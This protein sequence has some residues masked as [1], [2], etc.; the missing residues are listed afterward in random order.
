MD[1][2]RLKITRAATAACLCLIAATARGDGVAN[3]MTSKSLPPATLAVIDPESGTSSGGGSTDVN[4]GPGDVIFF[5][6]N[7]YPVP[8]KIIRGLNTYLTEYIPSN[9]QVVGVRILDENGLA[10]TPF[11][12]GIAMDDCG[13]SCNNFNSVPSSAG[14]R[15]LD[16]GTIAQLYADTGV[17]YA[18]RAGYTAAITT[19]T[20]NPST[21]FLALTNGILMDPEPVRVG[22][23]STLLGLVGDPFVHNRWDWAQVRAFGIS[24]PSGNASGNNGTGNTPFRYGSP[25]AGP[26]TFYGFETTE[27]S[28]G[29]LRFDD[30]VGPWGRVQ[31]PGATIGRGCSYDNRASCVEP[32]TN[33]LG[34]MLADASTRGL[35]ITPASP[36]PASARALRFAL[37]EARVGEPQVVEVALRVLSTPLDGVQME[38]VD[39][40]EIFGGDT[41]AASATVRAKDNAWNTHL[42][43]PACVYLKLKFDLNVDRAL[44]LTGDLLTYTLDGSNL[45]RFDQSSVVVRQ[46]YDSS[47]QA[48]VSAIPAPTRQTTCGGLACLEWDLATLTPGE[49]FVIQSQF[50]VGGGGQTTN[51]MFAE[52]TSTDIPRFETQALTIVRPVGVVDVS[53]RPTFDPTASF[54]SAGANA[55]LSGTLGNT[56]TGD[57]TVDTLTFDLPVSTWRPGGSLALSCPGGT[58]ASLA[59]NSGCATNRPTYRLNESI[60]GGR[61]CTFTVP[62]AVPAGTAAGLYPIAV[63]TWSSQTAFGG[64]SETWFRDAAILNVGQRRSQRPTLTCPIFSPQTTIAGTTTEAIGTTAR[65]YLGGYRRGS[66]GASVAGGAWTV[67]TF[68]DAT[69]FGALYGGLEVRATAQ[70]TGELESEKSDACFVTQLPVCGD[71]LDNDGD[72]LVD[73]PADPGCSATNDRDETDVQCSDGIDNDGDGRIDFPDDPECSSPNDTTEG[74]T[75]QCSDGID[76]DGDGV[77]DFPADSDCT[78]ATDRIERAQPA[79]NDGVDND[80]DGDVDFPDDVGCHSAQDTNEV[81]PSP[82]EGETRARLL[83]VLDSSGSM[84]WN[85]CSDTFTGGDGS[86][87]CAGGDVSC[88]TCG[89]IGCGDGVA[90][91]SRLD[92]AKR[93]LSQVVQGFG[94]VEYGLMRFHQRAMDFACPTQNASNQSG[95]WQGA[96]APVCG[97]GFNAADLLVGFSQEN[98]RDLLAWMDG[99]SGTAAV[100]PAGGDVEIRGSGTTPLAGSLTSAR[101]YLED[102]E[103][104]D[105]RASCRPYVVILVTD[106]VETCGGNPVAAANALRLAGYVTYVVGFAV[107][108]PAA[109]DSL[110]DIAAAGGGSPTAIFVSDEAE[111]ATRISDIIDDTVLVE[112]CNGADDDCDTLIDE[113]VQNACGACGAVP[114]ETCNGVDDDCDG[115]VDDGVR[116]ACGGCGPLP[117]EACNGLD[118]DCDG[119]TDEGGVCPCPAPSPELCDDSDNDCDGIVDEGLVRGCGTEVGACSAGTETCAAGVWGLCTGTGPTTETCNGLD[120][121]CDGIVDGVTRPCGTDVGVCQTGVEICV[122]GAFDTSTCVGAVTG[123]AELCNTLDDDCDGRTDEGT[124]PATSCGSSLGLCRP[125]TLRCVAGTLQCQGGTAPVAETCD[126]ADQDCDG[127]VDEGA[128]TDGPCG[129]STG[130][131]EPGVRTCVMGSYQCVGAVGPR[132]EMCNAVDDDCDG[133]LD[134]GNPGGGAVCGVTEGACEPG[135]TTCVGGTLTCVGGVEPV[136]ELCNVVDDDCDG[137]VDEGNPGGGAPCGGTDVGECELG[138]EACRAGA[139]VCVGERRPTTELCNGLDDDCDGNVDEGNPEAGDACG[140]DTGECMPGITACAGGELVCEGAIGPMDEVCNGLDDDCDGVADDGLD[141]GAPCGSDEGECIPGF[142]SCVDGAIVCEGEVGPTSE[143]CNALDDDCDGS[144]DEELPAGGVCGDT[145]GV[146]MPGMIQ[147]VDGA[148]VCVG[149]VPAAD[150]RCDC[151]DN[152]C[153]G[154]IDEGSLCGATGSCVDC[155]CALPCSDSEFG[156]CPTGRVELDVDGECFCV[157]PRC[158]PETCGDETVTAGDG[159]VRCAPGMDGVP[160]CTCVANECTFP[161]DGVVCGE[162]TVCNPLTGRCV[163]DDCTGLGC[164]STEV[165]EISTGDC[166]PHPCNDVTC[167]ATEACRDGVCEPSCGSTTCDDGE[168]CRAGVC[169]EDPCDGVSCAVGLR[170]DDTGECVTNPCSGITCPGGTTCDP[171]DGSCGED[172]CARVICPGEQR[173][174]AGECVAP[175]PPPMDGG[176]PEEDAGTMELDAGMDAGGEPED[177]EDRILAAG[178]GGCTCRVDA[179]DV[180]GGEEPLSWFVLAVPVLIAIRRRRGGVR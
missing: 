2:R 112:V 99:E 94:E 15:N 135:T 32:G 167:G 34:R 91:D 47:R 152:D 73:F 74:G 63:Q 98:Q 114:V 110:D 150:E 134:E 136:G 145:E 65:V 19:V 101:D 142:R 66:T 138:A 116:N 30:V 149:G 29:N 180:G 13:G 109:R 168:R 31:Y 111:L 48:F 131:C 146:C 156:R 58:N 18:P 38:D 120:D 26:D 115:V 140:D 82:T 52:Y 9:T 162:P 123:G 141:V 144:V 154:D 56:G 124:D 125:G 173:C 100:P 147:C 83:L 75:P 119:A 179:G 130:A 70:A 178:G 171:T 16:N 40:A 158:N 49:D 108:D 160:E 53:L 8:D 76:N 27:V 175:E 61:T 128:P 107:N 155:Q 51:V 43:S 139:I 77:S 169:E 92:K 80:G 46:R 5:R 106:G 104:M 45:S 42:A 176:V 44:A 78:S 10:R 81:D 148:E 153:D 57:F 163:V 133:S 69:A 122:G 96:G 174:E 159:T 20:R 12:P 161:C 60:P 97:G 62:V 165:C 118:D 1:G 67:G 22:D 68:G 105:A 102:V 72:G 6:F 50:T 79:C 172:P 117:A 7:Y 35:D 93:G 41:S 95:G 129:E 59:C 88:A 21:S 143:T 86:D 11:Y 55:S 177:P 84:N 39:C 137:L 170:C 85:T 23:V 14:T 113:G 33:T 127:R 89:A 126:G 36:L 157:A 4:V 90:N 54:A 132:T 166:I 25:V 3:V 103:A 121:D 37:G 24:N 87:E 151:D 17:F 71:G 64:A 164:L 28:A